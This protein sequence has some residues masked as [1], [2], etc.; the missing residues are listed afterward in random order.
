M[1]DFVRFVQG[2][3]HEKF[4]TTYDLDTTDR[5]KYMYSIWVLCAG[6]ALF[7]AKNYV[8]QPLQCWT[9]NQFGV[10]LLSSSN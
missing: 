5:V 3:V 10:C 2:K 8:G 4:D 6:S 1:A 9:P 7:F